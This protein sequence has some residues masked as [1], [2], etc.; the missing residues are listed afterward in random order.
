MV[1]ASSLQKKWIEGE[2]LDTN[3]DDEV[4]VPKIVV[5]GGWGVRPSDDLVA[6]GRLDRDVLADGETELG[7]RPV[8]REAVAA[9]GDARTCQELKRHAADDRKPIRQELTGPYCG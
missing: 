1:L 6:D 7:G 3:L 4:K 9:A 8:E 2:P 5:A